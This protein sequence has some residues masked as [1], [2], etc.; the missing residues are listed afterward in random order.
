MKK[1]TRYVGLDVHKDTIS[2]AVAE[3]GRKGEVRFHGTIANTPEA[4][5]RLV[6][7]LGPA[8]T[9]SCCYEAGP[10]GYVVYWHLVKLGA[11]CMVVAPSLI[12]QKAGDRVK[13]DRRDAEKLARL[14]RSGELTAVWVPDPAHEALRD[15]VRARES[16]VEDQQRARNRL[17]KFL[18]RRGLSKPKGWSSW[19]QKHLRW[20]EQQRLEQAIDQ[21][22]LADYV[23][24][25]KHVAERI[26]RLDK[27]IEEA[28]AQAPAETRE[29]IAA[30]AALRGVGRITATTLVVEVGS[31]ERFASPRELMAYCG[32]VPREHSSG[33]PGKARRGAITKAGNAHVRRVLGEAAWHYATAKPR[34]SSKLKRRQQGV[35]PEVKAISDRAQHRLCRRYWALTARGKPA[36]TAVTAVARELLGFVWAIG[37]EVERQHRQA[38]ATQDVRRAA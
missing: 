34:V 18:L 20:V 35:S 27:T 33:G 22:T 5:K 26:E 6:K 38:V 28:V 37:V 19:T 3:S 8:E 10:C 11:E 15:L 21:L 17:S 4:I 24:E 36:P 13:T 2:V 32:V 16:A 12:P 30:L 7:A 1:S 29:V 25:V 14:H 31:F 9:L 23:A